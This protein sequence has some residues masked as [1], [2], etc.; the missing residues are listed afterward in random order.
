MAQQA[1]QL[2]PG[3]DPLT[4]LVE[5]A[6]H[7][8]AVYTELMTMAASVVKPPPPLEPVSPAPGADDDEMVF[9]EDR[10]QAIEDRL[11]FWRQRLVELQAVG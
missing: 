9:I 2:M 1:S 6:E 10:L 8:V 5:D 7:W 4:I 11:R 3:E